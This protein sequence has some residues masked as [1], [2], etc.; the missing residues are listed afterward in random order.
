MIFVTQITDVVRVRMASQKRRGG[1][2]IHVD[3]DPIASLA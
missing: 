1:S 2:V 3:G